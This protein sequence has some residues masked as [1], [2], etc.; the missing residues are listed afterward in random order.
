M[1]ANI[2]KIGTQPSTWGV[3][4]AGTSVRLALIRETRTT[5]PFWTGWA[6][7]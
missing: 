4:L 6:S 1:R 7:P 3:S 2:E 5:E